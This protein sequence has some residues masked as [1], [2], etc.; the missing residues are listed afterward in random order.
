[1]R[2]HRDEPRIVGL[3]NGQASDGVEAGVPPGD[4]V[5]DGAAE[6]SGGGW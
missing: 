1:M 6:R 2:D 3:I 4:S 5:G